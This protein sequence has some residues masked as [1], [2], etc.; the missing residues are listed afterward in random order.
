[1]SQGRASETDMRNMKGLVRYVTGNSQNMSVEAAHC[2]IEASK[3][4]V[5]GSSVS[6]SEISTRWV[7]QIDAA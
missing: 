2:G 4:A 1:M 7:M 6:W 5:E 3:K